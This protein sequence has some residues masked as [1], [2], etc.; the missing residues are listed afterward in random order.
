MKMS[1]D[2]SYANKCD[3]KVMYVDYTNLPS[4]ISVGKSIYVD[5]GILSFRVLSISGTEV[6]VEAINS[7]TLASKKGVN[8]PGTEVDLPAISQKDKDDLTFG[9]KNGVDMIFASFIRRGEDVRDIRAHLGEAGKNIKI[10]VKIE[11]L[12]GVENFDEILRETDG[13]M[14]ARGDLGIEIPASQVFMA[15]KMMI[16]KCNLAG[17]PCICATQMLESMTVR[18]SFPSPRADR[19][20]VQPPAYACR[21]V[22]RGERGAGRRGLCDAL[23]RDGQGYLPHRGWCVFHSS[24]TLLTRSRSRDDGRNVLP[25]R[26]RHLLPSSLQRATSTCEATHHHLRDGR[27]LGRRGRI[28]AERRRYSRHVHLWQHG[29]TREQVPSPLSS[30]HQYVPS[31]R[32]ARLTQDS[33]EER[34]D[35][36]TDPLEP[37]LLPDALRPGQAHLRRGMA[38]RR[39]LSP[40]PSRADDHLDRQPN[41]LRTRK[42]TRAWHP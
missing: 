7:G 13:V 9:V 37:R 27:H 34:A 18:S 28:G 20:S 14:V 12:Q 25:R 3:D 35:R 2:P 22:G 39:T 11:N 26:V 19:R 31:P 42:R 36:S 23:G 4:V 8:L 16:A 17:K 40:S 29:S 38:N 10:I 41:P 30:H 21:G 32:L 15:Q 5:D 33:H 1:V 6:E 24:C